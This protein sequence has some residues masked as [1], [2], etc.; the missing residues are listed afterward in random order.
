MHVGIDAASSFAQLADGGE[1]PIVRLNCPQA[2]VSLPLDW[3]CVDLSARIGPVALRTLLLWAAT[4]RFETHARAFAD[5][6]QSAG[7]GVQTHCWSAADYVLWVA[8]AEAL[9]YG[10]H[11]DALRQAGIRLLAGDA[12]KLDDAG[13]SEHISLGGLLA[14]W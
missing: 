5:A 6:L 12:L 14:L 11:R 2:P 7:F 10:Q 8:L 1:T 9:G 13:R 3:P 4:E